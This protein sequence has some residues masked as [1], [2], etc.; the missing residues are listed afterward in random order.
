MVWPL[1][2]VKAY[3]DW[4]RQRH[5]TPG[6]ANQERHADEV[7]AG[8]EDHVP[9]TLERTGSLYLPLERGLAEPTNLLISLIIVTLA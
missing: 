4:K 6:R 2:A 3:A 9:A 7:E 1:L 5:P 8:H